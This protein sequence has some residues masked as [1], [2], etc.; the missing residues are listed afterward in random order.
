MSALAD[1]GRRYRAARGQLSA[2]ERKVIDA[3]ATAQR[4]GLP[5]L[6]VNGLE[7]GR[8]R[9]RAERA[10][11]KEDTAESRTERMLKIRAE[12]GDKAA[13]AVLRRRGR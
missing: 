13:A 4:R 12:A 8:A 9:F 5:G 7:A 10:E 1:G 3:D 6:N 11:A 2:E